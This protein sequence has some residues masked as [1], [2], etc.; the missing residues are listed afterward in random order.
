MHLLQIPL[1][2][3]SVAMVRIGF[4]KEL[5]IRT[6][7]PYQN[8]G[9]VVISGVATPNY[10]RGTPRNWTLYLDELHPTE[11]P[12]FNHFVFIAKIASKRIVID[13]S[14]EMGI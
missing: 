14:S 11:G 1:D 7:I 4:P 2:T 9:G 6:V 3:S 12:V 8:T 5:I 10:A 13:P